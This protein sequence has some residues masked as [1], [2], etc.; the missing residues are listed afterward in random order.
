MA[1]SG[2]IAL[3]FVDELHDK[4]HSQF[5]SEKEDLRKYKAKIVGD[6]K[7]E[8]LPW[9][10]LYYSELLRKEKYDFDDELL[11]PYFP[12]D[13]VMSGVFSIASTLYGMDVRP[14][15]TF[16]RSSPSK[17]SIEGKVEVARRC[18]VLRSF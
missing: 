4:C 9:E 10:R 8:I 15:E 13:K 18:Q 6:E 2:D 17:P 7:T 3:H 11:R 5:L 12:V 16:C 1:L 14:R